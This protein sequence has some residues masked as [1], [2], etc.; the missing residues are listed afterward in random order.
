MSRERETTAFWVSREILPHEP[1][2]RAWLAR[3]W[4]DTIDHD[5]VIQEAYCRIAALPSIDHIR[6]GRAYFFTTARAIVMDMFRQAKVVN[7]TD[8]TEIEFLDV[9]D[10]QP[11]ADRVTVGRQELKRIDGV[12]GS[13]SATCRRV[14]EL[15][16]LHGLSQKETAHKLGISEHSVENHVTRGVRK[17]MKIIADQDGGSHG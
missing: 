14:I 15:R 4:N 13:L 8:V 2:V 1:S 3:R 10:E 11:L 12:L 9:E 6:N 5:D 7:Q 17:V 16:R